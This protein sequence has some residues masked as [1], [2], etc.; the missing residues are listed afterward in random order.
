MS[1]LAPPAPVIQSPAEI[2]PWFDAPIRRR[3]ATLLVSC[4]FT[5]GQLRDW[6]QIPGSPYAARDLELAEE[7]DDLTAR[8]LT[9]RHAMRAR[10][11]GK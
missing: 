8:G 4:G 7:I 11:S 10:E 6:A 3:A 9:Q 2:E 5:A 1:T